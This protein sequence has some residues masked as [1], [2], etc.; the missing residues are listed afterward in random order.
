MAH[1]ITRKKTALIIADSGTTLTS[2]A[3]TMNG[4]LR[5]VIVNAPAMTSSHTLTVAVNDV[6]SQAVFSKASIAGNA[7]TPLFL[8]AN[9]IPYQAPLSGDHTIVVTSSGAETGA[10]TI[11]VT[12]LVESLI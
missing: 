7:T 11:N 12:L 10:K 8:D 4:L 2:A 6:D 5:G 3:I 1:I 9:N